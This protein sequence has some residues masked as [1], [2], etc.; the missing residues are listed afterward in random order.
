VLNHN[1]ATGPKW[2]L[3]LK[4]QSYVIFLLK[5]REL[6]IVWMSILRMF[7]AVAAALLHVRWSYASA[8]CLMSGSFLFADQLTEF[9]LLLLHE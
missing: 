9:C 8:I 4:N 5:A 2:R 6:L 3:V 1:G 7:Q